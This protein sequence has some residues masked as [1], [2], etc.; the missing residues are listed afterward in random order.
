[1]SSKVFHNSSR[2]ATEGRRGRRAGRW[3]GDQESCRAA[4]VRDP[5]CLHLNPEETYA[6]CCSKIGEC[7]HCPAW[8]GRRRAVRH[9]TAGAERNE[10]CRAS[11]R[12]G[13]EHDDGHGRQSCAGHG[14]SLPPQDGVPGEWRLNTDRYVACIEAAIR[15]LGLKR[16]VLMGSS[17]GGQICL[18]MAYRFPDSLGGV[19]AC[20][21]CDRITGRAVP[22]AK[23]ARYNQALA[24]PEWIY[25][26]MSPSTPRSRAIEIWWE[27]SQGGYG[28][29]HGDIDFYAHD[30]DA[31]ER[32]GRIDTRR[33]PVIMLTGEY[34]FSCTPE[35][36]RLTAARIPGAEFQ[37]MRGLGHFPMTENPEAFLDYLRPALEKIGTDPILK[38]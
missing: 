2:E 31:R 1:M 17:M 5:E 13:P 37:M 10:W 3:E 38:K 36:S 21:A 12:R 22:F 26:L 19:I 24:V 29:F 7:G 6:K 23:D 18:E 20:E 14:K 27:Y 28:I 34:D 9:R 11:A 8:N 16:P 25:G 33:C 35:M 4:S 32:V 30:W 15:G